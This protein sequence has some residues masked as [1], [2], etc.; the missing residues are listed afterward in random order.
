MNEDA[1]DGAGNENGAADA[2]PRMF[3]FTLSLVHPIE[4]GKK[5]IE[6]LTFR[7]G[8]M[9]DL[10]GIDLAGVT[11]VDN[12][13]TVAARMCGQTVDVMNKLEAE[14]AGEVLLIASGFMAACLVTGRT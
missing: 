1:D 6:S 5:V 12:I 3:P 13:I 14:D 10:R 7:R 11:K 2:P 9:G 4:H 8:K